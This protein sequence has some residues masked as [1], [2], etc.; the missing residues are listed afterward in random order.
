MDFTFGREGKV[1]TCCQNKWPLEAYDVDARENRGKTFSRE[2]VCT[3]CRTSQ[4]HEQKYR[5]PWRLWAGRTLSKHFKQDGY[6]SLAAGI[7]VTGITPDELAEEAER[8]FEHGKCPHCRRTWK[9][10]A[11]K[12]GN[13]RGTMQLDRRDPTKPLTRSNYQF[14]CETGNKQKGRLPPEVADI[15]DRCWALYEKND[16]W[17]KRMIQL[18]LFDE[19]GLGGAAA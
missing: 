18:P 10:L 9:W 5:N 6:A 16:C 12:T 13:P 8:E 2:S 11:K 1:C 4:R 19:D 14:K 15:R 3:M 17:R 7:E